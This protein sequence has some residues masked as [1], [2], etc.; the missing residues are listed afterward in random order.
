MKNMKYIMRIR[1]EK[2]MLY[3]VKNHEKQQN[4]TRIRIGIWNLQSSVKLP[5][6]KRYRSLSIRR[7]RASRTIC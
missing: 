7:I 2:K 4:L 5:I 1:N 3:I 6:I